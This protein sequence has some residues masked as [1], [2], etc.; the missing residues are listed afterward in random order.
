MRD[1]GAG[2]AL[3]RSGVGERARRALGPRLPQD[4]VATHSTR[5][6]RRKRQGT[7]H[8]E[9]MEWNALGRNVRTSAKKAFE[10]ARTYEY[11]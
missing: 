9:R 11:Y 5:L 6:S 1:G 2:F 3:D 4:R 8:R 10:R 7:V